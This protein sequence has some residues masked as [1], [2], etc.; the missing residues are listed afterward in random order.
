MKKSRLFL[1]MPLLLWGFSNGVWGQDAPVPPALSQPE[2]VSFEE[3]FTAFSWDW[4]QK[5]VAEQPKA[6]WVTSPLGMYRLLGMLYAGSQNK[7]HAQI[8]AA[9]GWTGSEEAYFQGMRD[10]F[11]RFQNRS[12]VQIADSVWVQNRFPLDG[13]YVGVLREL[14]NAEVRN[15]DFGNKS[16]RKEI[17]GWISRQTQGKIPQLLQSLPKNTELLLCDTLTFSGQWANAFDK[18][19]TRKG[20]FT[21]LEGKEVRFPIM[22][23]EGKYRYWKG[24]DFQWLELP[25]RDGEFFMGIFLPQKGENFAE[26]EKRVGASLIRDCLAKA[27][28]VTVDVRIPRF[29]FQGDSQ[30]VPVLKKMGMED[31]F[32]TTADFSLIS[33]G[34]ELM[35]STILQG[36]Y[37]K[38][39][40]K[41]TEAASAAAAEM[42]WKSMIPKEN[43]TFYADRP[44]IFV[45]AERKTGGILFMGRFVDPEAMEKEMESLPE[46]ET[47]TPSQTDKETQKPEVKENGTK[48]TPAPLN[49]H[50]SGVGGTIQ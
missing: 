4:Y 37:L 44:F 16:T 31:A 43:P 15:I 41:G 14:G 25:Y 6:N 29:T 11:L 2:N 8:A 12:E 9:M 22:Q 47:A 24:E 23:R 5:N 28:L 26:V 1:L 30:A 33:K 45:I 40:E 50:T 42:I 7:T 38:V 18:R 21:S 3:S 13:N 48:S 34:N 35:V 39:D 27:S 19:D 46:L 17:N 49:F 10:L 20:Y 32:Q 36:T